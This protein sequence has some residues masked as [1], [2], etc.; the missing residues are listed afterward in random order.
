MNRGSQQRKWVAGANNPEPC[1]QCKHNVG[2]RAFTDCVQ[3]DEFFKKVCT[4]CIYESQPS[5]TDL[6]F[7]S[8]IISLLPGLRTHKCRTASLVDQ[9]LSRTGQKTKILFKYLQLPS[10]RPSPFNLQPWQPFAIQYLP[11]PKHNLCLSRKA[12]QEPTVISE[13]R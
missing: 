12:L 13:A 10:T 4:N 11:T 5:F 6:P 2:Q 7:H 1:L 8:I 3:A 9:D